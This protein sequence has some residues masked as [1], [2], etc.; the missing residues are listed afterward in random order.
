ML[1]V[2][3]FGMVLGGIGAALMLVSGRARLRSAI[4]FGP[5]LA[6]RAILEML[7]RR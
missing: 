5:Y 3:L 6:G 7:R 4:A 1:T 2:L